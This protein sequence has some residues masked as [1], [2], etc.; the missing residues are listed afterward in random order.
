LTC[1]YRRMQDLGLFY[2]ISRLL[3]TNIARESPLLLF[4]YIIFQRP[5]I[6]WK[7]YVFLVMTN[8]IVM[9]KTDLTPGDA[10]GNAPS[11]HLSTAMESIDPKV[12]AKLL[13]KLDAVFVPI[14][15]VVYLACFLDR[16]NIG[17]VKVA[18][19]PED[20]G[21]SN[22][23]FSTAVSIFYATYVASETPWS[24]LLKYLTPRLVLISLCT[25][26]SLVTI[27]SGL[28][29]SVGALY[30]TRLIL[31]ACEGGL[32]PALNLYLTM[33]YKR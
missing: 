25:V 7:D 27:F 30:A 1:H 26:W 19:M 15:M 18:G 4:I 23:Q 10:T 12:E 11:D 8:P 32:F 21:A 17:N 9:E 24:V 14:I 13:V 5:E 31:G 28:M 6:L 22:E 29:Q 2:D 16:S 33:V 3:G 20:I